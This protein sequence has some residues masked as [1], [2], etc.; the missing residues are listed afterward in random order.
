MKIGRFIRGW[1][2]MN[3]VVLWDVLVAVGFWVSGFCIGVAFGMKL[4]LRFL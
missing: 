2:Y 3:R 4:L 1:I